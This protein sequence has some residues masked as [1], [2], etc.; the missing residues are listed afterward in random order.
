M[1]DGILALEQGAVAVLA[2]GVA[3]RAR[4]GDG[5]GTRAA[6]TALAAGFVA[7][8]WM[9]VVA[10]VETGFAGYEGQPLAFRVFWASLA[11][12]DPVTALVLVVRP[13]LGI[14]LTLAVLIAD[15]AINVS[16]FGGGWRI[17]SQAGFLVFAA[18]VG[19]YVARAPSL[20]VL[21]SRERSGRT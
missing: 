7:G 6:I 2:A 12:V 19:R 3:W 20:S 4:R 16:A 21:A 14:A 9:H 5:L 17:A 15:V 13:R 10:L 11:I 1:N 8:A 18:G